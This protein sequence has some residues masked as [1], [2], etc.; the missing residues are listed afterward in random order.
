MLWCVG[1]R[2]V[3]YVLLGGGGGYLIYIILGRNLFT[4]EGNLRGGLGLSLFKI[5]PTRWCGNGCPHVRPHPWS[6]KF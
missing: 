1:I 4:S 6:Y 3:Q 5:T 2:Y